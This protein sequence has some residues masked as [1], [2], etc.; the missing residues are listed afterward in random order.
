[1]KHGARLL[2]AVVVAALMAVGATV[3]LAHGGGKGGK[4]GPKRGGARVFTLKPDP[5]G[6]P[7]GIAVD[8]RS[9]AFYV[10]IT[11]DGAIYRGTLRSDTIS[12]FIPGTTGAASVGIKVRRGLLYAAGGAT[13]TIKVFDLATRQQVAAFET[14]T[15]GFLNDLVVT[16]RGDVYVTDSLRPTLWHVTRAQVRAGGGTPQALDVSSGI[17]YTTGFNLNGIVQRS[18]RRLIVVQTNTGKLFRVGLDRAGGAIADIDEVAGVSVPGGDGMLLDR[19]RLVVVQGGPPAQLA[20]VRL[21]GGGTSGVV[22]ATRQSDLLKRTVD[23]RPGGRSVPGRQRRLREWGEAI[24]G[25]GS[26]ALARMTRSRIGRSVVLVLGATLALTGR[27]RRVGGRGRDHAAAPAEVGAG[28]QRLPARR[29]AGDA[30]G[31]AAADAW[32]VFEP[33]KPRPAQGAAGDR[34][35]RLLRVRGLRPDVRRSSGTPCGRATSSSTRAGRPDIATPC[36][37]PFDIEPCMTSAVERHPRRPGVPAREPEPGA[38]AARSGRATSASRSAASSP[39]TSRTGTGRWTCPGRGRSSS[40]TRTTA[41]SP[42]SASRRWTTRWRAS[43]R[44]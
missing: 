25:C 1:M 29:L 18:G 6:N 21:F 11:A 22:R 28:R 10:S 27:P 4:G 38:A 36:P 15:G 39:R 14:G 41:A 24:H 23:R 37:G 35:A 30:P 17:A 19:G 32:Y 5:A 12:P 42:A 2:V 40:T 9:G 34:H 3:A 20:S 43:R 16:R 13:G 7:E 44:R 33:I 31:A 8:H 26:A